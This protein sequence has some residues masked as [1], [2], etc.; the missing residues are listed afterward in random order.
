MK[1]N[2]GIIFCIVILL[3]FFPLISAYNYG[4]KTYGTGVY[5]GVEDSAPEENE[6]N[7]EGTETQISSS[8]G[9]VSQTYFTDEKLSIGGNNFNLR[10]NDK[11]KFIVNLNTH[12]L[13]MQNFNSTT[14]RVLIR[15][16]PI[17]TYLEKEVLYGFDLNN[18][19]MKD[20]NVQYNGLNQTGARIFIQEIKPEIYLEVDEITLSESEDYFIN[21]ASTVYWIV[22]IILIIS[23]CTVIYFFKRKSKIS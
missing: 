5:I 13:T 7:E 16:D 2:S 18:D 19:S 15:S 1:I 4:N 20:I 23:A 10:Y 6:N 9:W 22:G 21:K 11:I 8:G 17:N 3:F 12:T 14:A